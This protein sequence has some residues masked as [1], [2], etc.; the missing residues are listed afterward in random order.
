LVLGVLV[1]CAGLLAVVHR[2]LL[3]RF[4]RAFRVDDPG[5]SD[6][7]VLLLGG[8]DHRPQGVAKLYRKELAPLVLVAHARKLKDFPLD[9]LEVSRTIL[10]REGVPAGAIIALPGVGTSTR[11]EATYARKYAEEHPSIRRL[12]VA[13]T[14]FH[15][16]R[17]RWIFERVFAGTG[18]TIRTAAIPHPDFG[19]NDWYRSDEGLVTYFTEAFKFLYYRLAY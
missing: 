3:E 2:P 19:E 13:T 4:A 15:T 12:T 11:E 7:I 14:S 5:Q 8:A 18:V 1:A 6:A 17:A 9:E 10:L 16:A